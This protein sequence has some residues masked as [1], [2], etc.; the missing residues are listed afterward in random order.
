[1]AYFTRIN[2]E[3][4]PADM[5]ERFEEYIATSINGE[6]NQLRDI[7]SE[8]RRN[9][10]WVV[11]VDGWIVGM[12]GIESRSEESTELRRMYLHRSYRGCG[13]AQRMLQRA[14]T[15]ARESQFLKVDP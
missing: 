14:E 13:I 3:L 9:A 5:R 10:F 11:A 6:L 1:V 4:T 12:F 15:R 7:S 2:R 8:A